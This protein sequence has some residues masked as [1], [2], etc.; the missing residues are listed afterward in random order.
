MTGCDENNVLTCQTMTIT[1]YRSGKLVWGN[2]PGGAQAPG[3]DAGSGTPA[4]Q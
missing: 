3:P 1:L 4:D 2:E